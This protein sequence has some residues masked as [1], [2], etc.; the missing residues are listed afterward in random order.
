MD[1]SSDEVRPEICLVARRRLLGCTAIGLAALALLATS[2]GFLLWLYILA[3][4]PTLVRMI[5]FMMA[6]GAMFGLVVSPVVVLAALGD[7]PRAKIPQ[8]TAAA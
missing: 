6:Y 4:S 1:G 5:A 8:K 2:G 3:A 7:T